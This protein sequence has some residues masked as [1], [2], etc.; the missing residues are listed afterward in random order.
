M[1]EIKQNKRI[2]QCLKFNL[3][4]MAAPVLLQQK[5][6]NTKYF[7]AM[8]CQDIAQCFGSAKGT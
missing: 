4:F 5:L 3:N 6:K 8:L 7:I 1:L 2:K